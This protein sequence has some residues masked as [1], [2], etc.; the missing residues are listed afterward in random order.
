MSKVE[1]HRRRR[2]YKIPKINRRLRRGKG[3]VDDW[4]RNAGNAISNE[5][6]NPDSLLNQASQKVLNELKHWEEEL[7]KVFDPNKNGIKEKFE[8]F[9]NSVAP[10]FAAIG[11]KLKHDLDPRLNGVDAAFRNSEMT[12]T[13]HSKSLVIK[14]RNNLKRMDRK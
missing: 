4:F 3:P 7:G 1:Y 11:D 5:F 6:T 10:A 8:Q 13:E 9:A 12:S 14:S 2:N